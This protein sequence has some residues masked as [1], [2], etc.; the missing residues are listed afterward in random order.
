MDVRAKEK[1]KQ[2]REIAYTNPFRRTPT[3]LEPDAHGQAAL[4]LS[5]STLH[6][7]VELGILSGVQAVDIVRTASDVKVEVAHMAGES[8]TRMQASLDLLTRIADSLA[9]DNVYP[10][11]A[12]D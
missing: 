10:R 1:Q 9:T 3:P 6:T 7:L 4:L 2:M 8:N 11:I 5:E 12:K